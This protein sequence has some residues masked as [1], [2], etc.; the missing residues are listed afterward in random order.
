MNRRS[1]LLSAL[2]Q[3]CGAIGGLSAEAS[4]IERE[5]GSFAAA[6]NGDLPQRSPHP[7]APEGG[8][9][10]I[11]SV[12]NV[13]ELRA[14]PVVAGRVVGT[15]GYRIVADGGGGFYYGASGEFSGDG[16]A[17]IAPNDGDGSS[18]WRLNLSAGANVRQ[19]GAAG[20]GVAD[21]TAAF[22]NAIA[23]ITPQNAITKKLIV[24]AGAYRISSSLLARGPVKIV[25]DGSG[26]TSLLFYGNG[27]ALD[28]SSPTEVVG[29]TIRSGAPNQSGV[30]IRG[31]VGPQVRDIVL[32][33]FD[34]IG[35]QLGVAGM[36]GVYFADINYLQLRSAERAGRTALLVDGGHV[37]NSNANLLRNVFTKGRWA[38]HYDIR[39]NANILIGG[40]AEPDHTATPISEVYHIRG[41][42]NKIIG[43][44]V[45]PTGRTMP[46]VFFRF[47]SSAQGN[48]IEQ[49]HWTA[50]DHST[51]SKIVD[52][53]TNNEVA[54]NQNGFNFTPS[55]GRNVSYQNLIPN[56]GFWNLKQDGMPV[57]W[58]KAPGAGRV[59]RDEEQVRGARYSMKFECDSNHAGLEATVAASDSRRELQSVPVGKFRSRTVTVGVWCWSLTPDF[60]AIKLVAGGPAVGACT[61]SGSGSWEFLVASVRAEATAPEVMIILRSHK[62]NTP[63]TGVCYFSEPILVIGNEIPQSSMPRPL[64]DGDAAIAGRLTWNP[65]AALASNSS[66][67]AVDEGNFFREANTA[68]T[69]IVDFPNGRAGQEIKILASSRNTVVANSAAIR[70]TTGADRVLYPDTLYKFIYDGKKWYEF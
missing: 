62:D 30:L 61:H 29:L 54:V 57:G 31:G 11:Q 19:F 33:D 10:I 24:P 55:S 34:A 13:D 63:A 60:G 5:R 45:E 65:P 69:T 39:G 7:A 59:A 49:V 28:C 48:R 16:G 21:D 17:T 12:K 18:V 26:S 56:A 8:A 35:F 23:C 70:T 2:G 46:P 64:D 41:N 36:A 50:T 27:W 25:G 67:P 66:A 6:V 58:R 42:G 37:P 51:Y 15:A 3:G 38:T 52:L 68:P 1:L 14:L 40:D 44:Y 4:D 32:V 20:D 43:P 53:G 9:T 47:D 22:M